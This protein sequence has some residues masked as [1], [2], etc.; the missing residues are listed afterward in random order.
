[1][2]T[3]ADSLSGPRL[4][5]AMIVR[6]E[7]DVLGDSIRSVRRLA[8]EIVVMDTG[9]SDLT[10]QLAAESA[11]RSTASPGTTTSPP[12]GTSA[13][14]MSQPIGS[15]GS[16]RASRSPRSRPTGC[17]RSWMAKPKSRSPTRSSW[18]SLLAT[19]V[20]RPS[21][22]P[23]LRLMPARAGCALPDAS[24]RSVEESLRRGGTTSGRRPRAAS[25]ATRGSANPSD[26]GQSPPR[27]CTGHQRGRG[28]NWP[29]RL[30]LAAGQAHSGWGKQD[31]ARQAAPPRDRGRP[32]GLARA[33][34]G[35]LWPADH[36]STTTRKCTPAS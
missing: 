3:R 26:S 21:R 9:S 29:P 27:S 6:D 30:L 24:A 23:S 28:G 31:Q 22:S 35:L 10:V 33:P 7:Q 19:W 34:G 16:T 20:P 12:R 2:K 13:S 8:D 14:A 15:C 11:P 5:V 4:A 36:F 17:G 32:A 1:M 18:R 25:F